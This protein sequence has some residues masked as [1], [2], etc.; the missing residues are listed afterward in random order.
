VGF[1]NKEGLFKSGRGMIVARRTN[2][3]EFKSMSDY[4]EI[5]ASIELMG[6]LD[7]GAWRCIE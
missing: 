4:F 6:N 2:A 3:D 7:S 5:G 1:V